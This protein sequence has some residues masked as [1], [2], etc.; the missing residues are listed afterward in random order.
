M[1]DL[2]YPK[3]SYAIIGA[4]FEGYKNKGCGFSEPVCQEFL[5]IE[6][7]YQK[8][9]FFSQKELKLTD[10]G[11]ELDQTCKPDFVCFE[12]IMVKLKAVPKLI[13]DHRAQILNYL[14]AAGMKLGFLVNFGPHPRVE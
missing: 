1:P 3:E 2:I 7:E 12:K 14:H 5:E 8:I 11:H 4:C 10:R 6:S 9:P 13:D